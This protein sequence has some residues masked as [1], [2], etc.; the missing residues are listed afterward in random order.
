M[1]EVVVGFGTGVG[2]RVACASE[3]WSLV[4]PLGGS[5]SKTLMHT[6]VSPQ[7]GNGLLTAHG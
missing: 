5:P 2:K 3:F 7:T 1:V 6:H 4:S